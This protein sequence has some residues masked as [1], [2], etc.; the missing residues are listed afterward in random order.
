MNF[1]R[2]KLRGKMKNLNGIFV[3]YIFTGILIFAPS[4]SHALVI[5]TADFIADE[6]R[7]YFNGFEGLPD[8]PNT[9]MDYIYAENNIR[10]EQIVNPILYD[11]FPQIWVAGVPDGPEGNNAWYPNSGDYGYTMITM[12]DGRDFG[13]IGLLVGSGGGLLTTDIMFE[14]YNDGN[15][16]SS[17]S[18]DFRFDFQ[19]LGFSDEIF[20]TLLLRDT[21]VSPGTVSFLDSNINAL[22][23]DSIE[24]RS[25]PE[26]SV[27]SLMGAGL[28]ILYTQRKRLIVG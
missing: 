13:N 4:I 26:P 2:E 9:T 23:I 24:V 5:Y 25:V 6:S 14:L 15:M 7:D 27:L 3:K 22:S 17:G 28:I 10:V 8:S 16:I 19:Y 21:R 18:V 1:W 11:P 20:D 12:E